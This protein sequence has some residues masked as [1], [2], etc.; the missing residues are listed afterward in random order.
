MNIEEE[1]K[2]LKKKNKRLKISN[3][4]M[5]VYI[6]MSLIIMLYNNIAV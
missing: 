4:I 2:S 5:L 1:I 6:L 3:G